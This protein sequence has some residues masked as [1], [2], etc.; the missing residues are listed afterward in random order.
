MA[1]PL[2][3]FATLVASVLLVAESASATTRTVTNGSDSGAGSLRDTIAASVAGDT[4]NFSAGVSTITLTSDSLSVNHNL[5]IQGP[6]VNSLTI[7]RSSSSSNFRIFYF[8]NGTWTL[9]GVTISN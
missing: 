8:D 3:R 4:I 6:G 1:A 2:C 9:S 7:T 5:T